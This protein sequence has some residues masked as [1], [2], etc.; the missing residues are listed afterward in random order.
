MGARDILRLLFVSACGVYTRAEWQS[1]EGKRHCKI[2]VTQDS[3]SK[4]L[5]AHAAPQ[6]GVEAT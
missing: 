5:F 6:K 3:M 1:D 2:L 4:C